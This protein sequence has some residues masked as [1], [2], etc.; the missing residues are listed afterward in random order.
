MD[1]R[2]RLLVAADAI[3]VLHTLFIAFVVFGL[4]LIIMGVIKK[5]RW[6]RGPCFRFLHLGAVGVVVVQ[7]WL[8]VVCPLTIWENKLRASAGE[9][10]YGGSFI[11]H[12]LHKLIFYQAEPW[13][14][15]LCYSLFGAG[16]ILALILS[17]P[18]LDKTPGTGRD[19]S[20]RLHPDAR[21]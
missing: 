8:G 11:Q 19:R 6:V 12:W 21:E 13:V 7:A 20:N 1:E 15:T 16:V 4:L 3:L 17:P 14:F 10:G 5:W 2:T 18:L 9:P